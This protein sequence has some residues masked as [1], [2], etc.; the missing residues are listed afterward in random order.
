MS[1][2][3]EIIKL[4][5][6]EQGVTK[7]YSTGEAGHK[8]MIESLT[9]EYAEM[10]SQTC[11]KYVTRKQVVNRITNAPISDERKERLHKLIRDCTKLLNDTYALIDTELSFLYEKEDKEK[12]KCENCG[13]TSGIICT[14]E[15]P[16]LAEVYNEIKLVRWCENCFQIARDDI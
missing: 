10:R 3:K 7:F 5:R 16:F 14:A 12:R 13:N 2:S 8:L 4:G 9:E 6:E 1:E 15:N 11:A